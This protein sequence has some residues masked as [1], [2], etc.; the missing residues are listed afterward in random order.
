MIR[1]HYK[2]LA[3]LTAIFVAITVVLPVTADAKI[4]AKKKA[5][6]GKA[7]AKKTNNAVVKVAL[8]N[9]IEESV[10]FAEPAS[11]CLTKQ[12]RD[13]N[14]KAEKQLE[15]DVAKYGEGHDESVKNYRYRLNMAWDAMNLPYCGFGSASSLKDEVHSFKKSIDRARA[16]FLKETKKK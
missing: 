12:I 2:F 13:L 6:S 4:A 1:N 11:K 10:D 3:V 9:S 5:V 15:T 14:Q 16:D 7:V 8:S